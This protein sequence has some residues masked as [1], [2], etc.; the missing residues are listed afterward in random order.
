[1]ARRRGARGVSAWGGGG[2]RAGFACVAVAATQ[3]SRNAKVTKPQ[4]LTSRSIRGECF[5][6]QREAA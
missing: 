2:T 4:K 3:S 1:M 5:E 6:M